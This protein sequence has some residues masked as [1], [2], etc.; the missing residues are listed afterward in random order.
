[1]NPNAINLTVIAISGLFNRHGTFAIAKVSL[2]KQ[3][4]EMNRKTPGLVLFP[5]KFLK[6]VHQL[7]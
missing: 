4:P 1:M 3:Q 6:N 5:H 7:G 2:L